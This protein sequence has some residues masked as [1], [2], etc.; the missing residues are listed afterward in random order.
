MTNKTERYFVVSETE[1]VIL[2]FKSFMAGYCDTGER[3]ETD[4]ADEAEAACRARPFEKYRAVVEAAE[5]LVVDD[6]TLTWRK[7]REALAALEEDI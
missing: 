3:E 6:H 2:R 4:E 7:M 5:N 1:L